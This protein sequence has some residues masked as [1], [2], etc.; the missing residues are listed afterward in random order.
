MGDASAFPTAAHLASYAGPTPTTRCSGTSIR[1][2][3]PPRGG[4]K[5][6]KRAL[7]LASFASLSNPESRA[8][9]DRR[10]ADVLHAMLKHR[11]RYQPRHE[12]AA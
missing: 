10:R 3:G 11:T 6:I 7:F 1:G 5:T 9:Y 8:Y 2:E 12:Q 4:N